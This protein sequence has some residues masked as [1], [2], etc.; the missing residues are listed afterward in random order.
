MVAVSDDDLSPV[1]TLTTDPEAVLTGGGFEEWCTEK[2]IVYPGPTRDGA[3][4][5]TG[6]TGAAIAGTTLTDKVAETRPGS[7]G[8]YAARL[9]SKLVGIAGVGKLAAGNLFVGKYIGTRGTNGIV[10]FGR[11]FTLRPTALHG[12]VKYTC[13]NITD[14][15]TTQPPGMT[16][17]KGDPDN[18]IEPGTAFEDLPDD[19]VCPLCQEGKEVFEAL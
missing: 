6:N 18:G 9:E 12:W 15:G 4:W 7:P 14:V 10:G 19:W 1:T 2:D 3:Y 16:I 5:G 17:A 13:G 8:Q 11:P